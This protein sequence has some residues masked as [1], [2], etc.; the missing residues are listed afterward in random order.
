MGHNEAS[1]GRR[2]IRSLSL[3]QREQ[4]LEVQLKGRRGEKKYFKKNVQRV[5]KGQGKYEAQK[6]TNC[7]RTYFVPAKARVLPDRCQSDRDPIV[8]AC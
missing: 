5:L 6:Y 1:V 2:L 8:I 3:S 7:G 4:E